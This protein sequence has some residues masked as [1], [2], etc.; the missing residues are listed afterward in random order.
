MDDVSIWNEALDM[1]QL[2]ALHAGSET[3]LTLA[4]FGGDPLDPLDDGTLTDPTERA[5]YVHGVLGTWIGD[6]NL[7]GQFNSTDFVVVFTAAEY[8]DGLEGN[9]S[10]VTG[11]WNGDNIDTFAV[12]RI[13]EANTA[14]VRSA[15][16]H[17][18][19]AAD[20]WCVGHA[21][22]PGDSATALVDPA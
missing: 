17:G 5:D 20:E 21:C 7:D 12:R 10:W 6:S 1:E 2:A 9:S 11:D 3:P 14:T 22:G 15:W 16:A 8:E 13:A 19:S 4:G 18:P